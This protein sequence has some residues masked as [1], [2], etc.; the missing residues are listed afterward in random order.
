MCNFIFE[1]VTNFYDSICQKKRKEFSEKCK[2][3]FCF[4][5]IINFI[6]KIKIKKKGLIAKTSKLNVKFLESRR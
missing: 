4:K 6:L 1:T 3:Q 5:Q 2:S